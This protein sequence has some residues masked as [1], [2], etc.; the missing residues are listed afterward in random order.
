MNNAALKAV[1]EIATKST[2]Y[3]FTLTFTR[4]FTSGSLVG[5]THDDHLGFCREADAHEWVSSVNQ[6]NKR[7]T[8]DYKVIA[9][10]VTTSR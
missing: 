3:P 6:A 7:G 4:E 5:L 9:F 8:L 10:A 2:P 1:R